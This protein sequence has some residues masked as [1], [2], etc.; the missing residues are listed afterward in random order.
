MTTYDGGE[1]YEGDWTYYGA[2]YGEDDISIIVEVDLTFDRFALVE[3]LEFTGELY[4]STYE[5]NDPDGPLGAGQPIQY[6]GASVSWTDITDKVQS[7]S[8]RRGKSSLTTDTF[9]GGTATI[10]L[11]DF[12]SDFL[13]GNL[14]SPYYPNVRPM[15]PIRVTAVFS[16]EYSRLFRGYIDSW[17]VD[18]DQSQ[19]V[20]F[21]T[22]QASDAFKVLSNRFTTYA[23]AD[24]DTPGERIE[25]ILAD[26]T[27]PTAFTDI[28]L[29]GHQS[30]LAAGSGNEVSVLAALQ[31]VEF[32]DAGALFIDGSGRV[33]FL[34]QTNAYPSGYDYE[35]RDDSGSGAI[36]FDGI[37]LEVS[38]ERL[39]NTVTLTNIYGDDGTATDT[40][41][42]EE[43]DIR[44]FTRGDV[45][46]LDLSNTEA[47]AQFY[48]DRDRQPIE[49]VTSISVNSRLSLAVMALIIRYELMDPARIVLSVPGGYVMTKDV[50]LGSVEHTIKP[51]DWRTRFTTFRQ[52]LTLQQWQDLS[53]SATEWADVDSLVTWQSLRFGERI[54]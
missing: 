26:V 50:Y 48:L 22:I 15:R 53:A 5:Y 13:P 20:A 17:T 18:W 52:F 2:V 36:Q 28:D 34:G 1:D 12:S 14:A 10:E 49:R 7:V 45:L 31:E 25:D 23:G 43:N 35:F 3:D 16:G 39:Y 6:S 40:D 47:L 21:V 32:A 19:T 54:P 9:E 46:T 4:E 24:G 41:S 44:E 8:I 11:R 37:E 30:S 29:A 42:Q 33:K 27:W 38:D 51:G